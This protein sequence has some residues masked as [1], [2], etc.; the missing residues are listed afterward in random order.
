MCKWVE[1]TKSPLGIQRTKSLSRGVGKAL[2]RSW[3]YITDKMIQT[4]S[5][6]DKWK[7][8]NKAAGVRIHILF[9]IQAKPSK[10]PM[11]TQAVAAGAE[12]WEVS[13][14]CWLWRHHRRVN[15]KW[16]WAGWGAGL[17]LCPHRL[18]SRAIW[19]KAT[20]GRFIED[21]FLWI[22]YMHRS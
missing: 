13:F 4:K 9:R 16:L 11:I 17:F 22:S 20:K 18:S 14:V 19:I 5:V 15:S 8:I 7:S 6:T 12:D 3:T 1:V 10:A 2:W 21:K